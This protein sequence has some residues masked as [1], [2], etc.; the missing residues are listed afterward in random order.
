MADTVENTQADET[1]TSQTQEGQNTDTQ[2]VETNAEKNQPFKIFETQADFDKH[3]AG[4]LNSA[5]KKAEKELL[6]MLGL[7]PDEKD[8]LANFK[9]AYEKTLSESEKQAKTLDELK[10]Q[11][12][13]LQ[14][15]VSSKDAIIA[16]LSHFSGKK[17][18]DVDKVVKM[19]K[20]LVDENTTIQ[21]ALEQVF[22]LT[23]TKEPIK[24]PPLADSSKKLGDKNPFAKETFNM[25]EQGHLINEDRQKAREL[26]KLTNGVYPSW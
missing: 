20:G 24:S 25:T 14:E 9:E 12:K 5:Q 15:E 8:K 22:A 6:A 1:S 13:S 21:D 26:Y 17:L 18:E 2:S 4:I 7:K 11:V 3:S 23:K 19:A 10:N 16:A